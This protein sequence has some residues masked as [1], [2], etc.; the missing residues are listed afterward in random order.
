M[1]TA[2]CGTPQNLKGMPLKIERHASAELIMI[3]RWKISLFL[4]LTPA[5]ASACPP[6]EWLQQGVGWQMCVPIPGAQGNATAPNRSEPAWADRWGAIAVDTAPQGSV[7]FFTASGMKRK[8]QAE[9]A[10]LKSCREK[11]GTRCEIKI[12]YYNQCAVLVWGDHSFNTSSAESEEQAKKVGL[13][14]CKNAGEQNCEVLYS[15]CSIPER[16]R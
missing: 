13:D 10:V 3:T 5:S 4:L 8:M 12:L 2:P 11:G 15:G 7:G 6:G 16:I 1:L 9:R 14:K